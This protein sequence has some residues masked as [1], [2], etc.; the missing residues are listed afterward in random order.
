MKRTILA[1]VFVLMVIFYSV[2]FADGLTV[3]DVY[4]LLTPDEIEDG[5]MLDPVSFFAYTLLDDDTILLVRYTW[6][7]PHVSVPSSING[8]PVS[9]LGAY[10]FIDTPVQEIELPCG[11]CID[12][13]AFSYCDL[14]RILVVT[15]ADTEIL[16]N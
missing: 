4:S 6:V 15:G 11:I 14:K 3:M 9:A 13:D 7:Q 16:M 12:S 2:A 8:T 10:A 1:I 5:V